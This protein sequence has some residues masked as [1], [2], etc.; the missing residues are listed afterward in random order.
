MSDTTEYVI[1]QRPA[2]SDLSW[3]YASLEGWPVERERAQ[4]FVGAEA[5]NARIAELRQLH[6]EQSYHVVPANG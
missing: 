3:M 5:V 1:V 4:V 2:R 6:R